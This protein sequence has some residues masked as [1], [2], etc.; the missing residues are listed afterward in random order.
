MKLSIV[1]VSWNTRDLLLECL[2]SVYATS[3]SDI[4]VW[5]VDNASSDG[6]TDAVRQRFADVNVIVNH[7]NGG[8]ARANNQAIENCSGQYILLLNPDTKVLGQAL[9]QLVDHLDHHPECGICGP[10]LLNPDNTLQESC[11]PFPTLAREFWRLSK[12]DHLHSY[13]IYPMKEWEIDH[14]REVDVIQG[15]AFL[16]RKKCLDQI[17]LLDEDYFIYTEEVDLCYRAKKARWKIEWIPDAKVIHYGGQSTQQVA[18]KMFLMLYATKVIFFRK[19][20]GI[21]AAWIYKMILLV[22]A[23]PR[24]IGKWLSPDSENQQKIAFNYSQLIKKLSIM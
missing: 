16:V 15:A 9:I 20:Y 6:T 18:T 22:C 24:I 5:V 17:G 2:T 13:G 7:E 23:I 1:I 11:Y 10:M 19:H 12:L 21:F 8:F 3:M 14:P 4:E